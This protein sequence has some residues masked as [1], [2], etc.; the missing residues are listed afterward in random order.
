VRRHLERAN[1]GEALL[2]HREK[3]F[4][5]DIY[6]RYVGYYGV[7]QAVYMQQDAIQALYS[8]FMPLRNLDHEKLTYWNKLRGMRNDTVGHPV[9]RLQRLNRNQ[10]AYDCVTYMRRPAKD[11]SSLLSNNVDL[12]AFLDEY[13]KEASDLLDAIGCYMEKECAGKHRKN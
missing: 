7:L 11:V 12:G 2:A 5:S 3:G 13:D 1:A 6:L 9:G 10:I 8:L 4:S